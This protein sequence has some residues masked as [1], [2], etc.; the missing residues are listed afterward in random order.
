MKTDELLSRAENHADGLAQLTGC[1]P[2]DTARAAIA[3]AL[4]PGRKRGAATPIAIALM[5]GTGAG[6]SSLFGLLTGD[7]SASPASGE[8]RGY[9]RHPVVATRD[10]AQARALLGHVDGMRHH[11]VARWSAIAL[12]DLPDFNSTSLENRRRAEAAFEEADVLLFVTSPERVSEDE[13]LRMV[14]RYRHKH[15]MFVLNKM[16]ELTAEEGESLANQL[17]KRLSAAGFTLGRDRLHL[18]SCRD[19]EGR[20]IEGLRAA[21]E[22]ESLRKVRSSLEEDAS[23]QRLQVALSSDLPGE[24]EE[25][26]S[27]ILHEHGRLRERWMA[28][29]TAA[30]DD[31]GSP[32]IQYLNERL[33]EYAWIHCARKTLWPI[34]LAI[35]VRNRAAMVQASWF[36]A[37]S[38]FRGPSPFAIFR[39][40]KLAG[41]SLAAMA[42]RARADEL[43]EDTVGPVARETDRAIRQVLEENGL[44][45]LLP[46]PV[47]PVP[48]EAKQAEAATGPSIPGL[49]ELNRQLG[50][51]RSHLGKFLHSGTK[52]TAST[53]L[54]NHVEAKGSRVASGRLLLA[55]GLAGNVIAWAFLGWV[56]WLLAVNWY[57]G[58]Y[59]PGA[60]Y[61]HSAVLLLLYIGLFLLLL[62]VLLRGAIRRTT[63]DKTQIADME[64]PTLDPLTDAA[65]LLRRLGQEHRGLRDATRQ[66]RRQLR[67]TRE[68]QDLTT[69]LD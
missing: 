25:R 48:A 55:L 29:Y 19:P 7:A 21:I 63:I 32:L 14:R 15:W 61:L 11:P 47:E 59:L 5:G 51:L 6:K 24:L 1:P 28:R 30:L 23:L 57:E 22:S 68:F 35:Q 56:F 3:K 64:L 2:A 26:A 58:T 13:I 37:R 20:G 62:H 40:G 53:A 33:H 43:L 41:G 60:F 27:A 31:P 42:E 16:D 4:G 44:A 65:E 69:A 36:L 52:G 50:G 46:P 39:L 45:G 67:E 49:S 18:V 54:L 38:V 8:R 12:I 9:T 17:V 10:E 34:S 66:R